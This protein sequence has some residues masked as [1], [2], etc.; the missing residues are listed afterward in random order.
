M[1]GSAYVFNK[2]LYFMKGFIKED[3]LLSRLETLENQLEI[4]SKVSYSIISLFAFD[5]I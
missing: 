2:Y 3:K 1:I 5:K 4:A